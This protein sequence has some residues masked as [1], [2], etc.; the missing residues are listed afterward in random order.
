MPVEAP[1]SAHA[2]QPE[3]PLPEKNQ[4]ATR[5]TIPPRF[6][7][8]ADVERITG[9]S[10]RTLQ[11][12]RRFNRIRFPWYRVGRKVLYDLDEVESIIRSTARGGAFVQGV[13][14]GADAARS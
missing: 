8:E 3:Q 2:A 13:R 12:D 6:G 7:S 11:A 9:Y 10:R 1:E 4:D 5:A 14:T